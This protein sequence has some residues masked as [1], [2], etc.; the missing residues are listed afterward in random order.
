MRQNGR[1]PPPLPHMHVDA[2]SIAAS[3]AR[4]TVL[5]QLRYVRLYVVS[6]RYVS[7]KRASRSGS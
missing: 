6:R 1:H 7:Q 4:A 5:E 2:P 3:S